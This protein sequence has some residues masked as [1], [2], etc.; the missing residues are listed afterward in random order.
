MVKNPFD[1]C[2]YLINRKTEKNK[3]LFLYN[4]IARIHKLIGFDVKFEY[5]TIN[6]AN[7]IKCKILHV[8]SVVKELNSDNDMNKIIYIY[9][10]VDSNSFQFYSKL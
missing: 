8:L 1:D 6:Y 10:H 2:Y 3:I 9:I 7:Q 4:K 5:C